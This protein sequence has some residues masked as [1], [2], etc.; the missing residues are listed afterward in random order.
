M[1]ADMFE[2]RFRFVIQTGSV[3]LSM[4]AD[5]DEQ[6][7]AALSLSCFSTLLSC[8]QVSDHFLL[9]TLNER[10]LI[11]GAT[12]RILKVPPGG[13]LYLNREFKVN[14]WRKCHVQLTKHSLMKICVWQV[15]F[16]LAKHWLLLMYWKAVCICTSGKNDKR[17]IP[18]A[19]VFFDQIH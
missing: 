8:G 10:T 6:D 2:F 5:F 9:S 19:K 12:R 15:A 4:F 1:G 7:G 13:T 3:K 14:R 18:R 16:L 17:T 11:I